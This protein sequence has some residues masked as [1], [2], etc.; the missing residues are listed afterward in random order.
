MKT[1]H[2]IAATS[3]AIIAGSVFYY[4]ARRKNNALTAAKP[5][6]PVKNGEERIRE[7]MHHAKESIAAAGGHA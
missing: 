3:A 5:A 4:L 1:K 7:V 2:I 6:R